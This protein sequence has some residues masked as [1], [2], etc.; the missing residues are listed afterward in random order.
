MMK[1]QIFFVT[2]LSLSLW[3]CEKDDICSESTPTTPKLI[4]RF[5]DFDNPDT[6]KDVEN[7]KVYGI[8]ESGNQIEI[9]G[10]GIVTTDSLVLPLP[11]HLNEVQFEMFKGYENS[12]TPGNKDVVLTGFQ[13]NDIYVSRACGFKTHYSELSAQ[14]TADSDQ[15]ILNLEVIQTEINNTIHAH[16]KVY[17]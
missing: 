7:L 8:D 4:I 11:T 16:V 1:F 13:T 12:E 3:Q 6:L 14:N 10:L 9:N 2:I 17:H 15:W 5:Y